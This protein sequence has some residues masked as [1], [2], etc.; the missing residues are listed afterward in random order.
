MNNS[1]A[2]SAFIML[3]N[4]HLYLAPKHFLFFFFKTFSFFLFFSATLSGS[5]DPSSP[6]RDQ[7]CAFGSENIEF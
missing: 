6:N 3:Y 2:F 7:A 5:R 4:Y 1:V